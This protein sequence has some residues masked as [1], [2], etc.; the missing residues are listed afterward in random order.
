M[1]MVVEALTEKDE[2][3]KS[4]AKSAS[5]TLLGLCR[6]AKKKSVG[7]I[8]LNLINPDSVP[9]LPK[10]TFKSVM[11]LPG[12][13]MSAQEFRPVNRTKARDAKETKAGDDGEDVRKNGANPNSLEKDMSE[14]VN[15]VK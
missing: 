9:S 4:A 11:M 3:G 1:S 15:D 7:M 2:E 5:E 12:R 8:G 14:K 6:G 10:P 13:G